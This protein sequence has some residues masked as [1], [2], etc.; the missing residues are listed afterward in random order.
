MSFL[1]PRPITRITVEPR[2]AAANRQGIAIIL[3]VKNEA[4]HI[5][6]W[7][8]FHH[9]AG[10]R[11]FFVYDNGSSDGTPDVLR[12]SLPDGALTVIPWSQR[13]TDAIRR[14]EIHNQVLAYA[15]AVQ[16]YGSQFRWFATIDCDEFLV[17]AQ[18]TNLTAALDAFD[19]QAVLTLHWHNFGRCGHDEIPQG[20]VIENYRRR[21][22]EPL[23]PSKHQRMKCIFDPCAVSAV[24]VH[25]M[26]PRDGAQAQQ[27][28][29]DA[30]QLNHYYTRSNAELQ[31][32]LARGPNV[33][34][35]AG[36]HIRRVMRRVEAIESD[37]VEDRTALDYLK[38][39][40][41][42]P[43]L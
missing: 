14:A 36:N 41:V 40:D 21:E 23:K 13:L 5:G 25:L 37:T 33:K 26:T 6:E 43:P 8:R 18:T 24:S 19:G 32:K 17:P 34:S 9:L 42:S 12:A 35:R 15:H 10:V 1:F 27:V 29:A 7:A 20:G 38:R 22:R 3:I 28:R 30:I 16:N 31:A 11:H 2:I 4:R 39:L